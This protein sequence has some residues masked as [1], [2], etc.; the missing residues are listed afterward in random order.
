MQPGGME[1]LMRSMRRGQSVE[2][3]KIGRET[4]RRILTFAQPYRKELVIFLITVVIGAVI[5][6]VTPLLAG[7]VINVIAPPRGVPRASDAATTVI[8]LALYIGGLAVI[9]ALL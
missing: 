6:V 4:A 7:D 8:R 2:N 9:S 1:H 3:R 5:G